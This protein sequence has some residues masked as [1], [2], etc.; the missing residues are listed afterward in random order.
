MPRLKLGAKFGRLTVI[1]FVGK[2]H[3]K[4][5]LWKVRCRCNGNTSIVPGYYLTNGTKSCGC[6]RREQLVVRNFKHGSASRENCTREYRLWK[7]IRKRCCNP[8]STRF[9]NYGGRGIGMYDPWKKDFKSFLN[10]LVETIGLCSTGM[11]IERI[12][13]NGN[14]EPGNLRWATPEEQQNNKRNNRV[15]T[16]RGKTQTLSR[17]CK[18]LDLRSNTIRCRL[19][20]GWPEEAALSVPTIHHERSRRPSNIQ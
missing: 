3:H 13:N 17:W 11:T 18:E 16:F 5:K 1:E 15:I 8:N 10:Y 4:Q 20:N 19:F 7:E 12:N 14:Y 2:N 6:L 9:E